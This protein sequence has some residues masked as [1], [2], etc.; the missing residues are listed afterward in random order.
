M[1]AKCISQSS[2]Y[3]NLEF[4]ATISRFSAISVSGAVFGLKTLDHDPKRVGIPAKAS[5]VNCL[6]LDLS[7]SLFVK[8]EMGKQKITQVLETGICTYSLNLAKMSPQ[9]TCFSVFSLEN[10]H[11]Y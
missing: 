10:R 3:C 7:C 4:I 9:C 8:S 6:G 2:Y 5:P 1:I 11:F